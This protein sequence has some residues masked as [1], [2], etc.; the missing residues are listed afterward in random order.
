MKK[1][2]FIL[3]IVMCFLAN[4]FSQEEYVP[5]DDDLIRN[6]DH[7]YID[8][9]KT[10]QFRLYGS[11]TSY[12]ILNLD[13]SAILELTFDD[14]SEE[15]YDYTYEV[16]HCNSDW[17][18]S[19]LNEMDYLK[20]FNNEVI[21]DYEFSINTLT[22]FINYS[23]TIPN[24]NIK[25]TKSGN[26]LLHIYEDGDKELPVLTRRFMVVEPLMQVVPELTRTG[27][28][29]QARSHQ[30]IDFAVLHKD[31][32]I[33]NPHAEVNVAVLQNGRWDNAITG[34]K[35][36][37]VKPEQL[38]YD[39]QGKIAFPGGKEYRNFSTQSLKYR[40][41]QVARIVEDKIDKY[42]VQ[43]FSDIDRSFKPY[44]FMNDLNGGF[45]IDNDDRVVNPRLGADYA[46]VHF[47]LLA[48][49]EYE[50]GSV[51][52]FGALTDWQLQDKYKM[53]YNETEKIY[54]TKAFLKQGYYDYE[55]AFVTGAGAKPDF[56]ELEGNSY[57]TENKYQVL[58]YYRPMG[59]RFDRLV[60]VSEV[61]SNN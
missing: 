17:T 36:L 42:H 5:N 1:L 16:V 33:N 13:G 53:T 10:V 37:F 47:S 56:S 28:V 15:V 43:L 44:I 6:Y 38:V 7:V 45:M 41:E 22:K 49:Q 58:V 3:V 60:A 11:L 14:L 39:Y 23:L 57:E 46:W 40:T 20:G 59:T 21:R 55:Y 35:P 18:K 50:K 30:E 25:I 8:G 24:Q 4:L 9:I 27:M 52:L 61:N 51:Y 34:V 54:A 2:F 12:P 32:T 26:Y 48:D 31:I 19:E 29:S